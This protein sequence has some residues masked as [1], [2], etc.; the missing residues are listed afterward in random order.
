MQLPFSTIFAFGS[1]IAVPLMAAAA[2]I[3]RRPSGARLH[4]PKT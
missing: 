2:L 3:V 4:P 1:A